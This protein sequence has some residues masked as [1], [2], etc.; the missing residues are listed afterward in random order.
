MTNY[1]DPPGFAAWEPQVLQ[2]IRTDPIWRTPAYRYAL[3]LSD[4]VELDVAPLFKSPETR[5]K[6]DQ[7]LRAAQSISANIADGYGRS[8]GAERAR[9]YEYAESSAREARDWYFKLRKYLT[10]EVVEQR[11]ELLLR[12]IKIL[13]AV[14]PRERVRRH[15][16]APCRRPGSDRR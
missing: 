7:L 9:F 16:L 5:E 4:L 10:P 2:S 11:D 3:W 15:R 14:I 6:A 13:T 1:T 8:S 12:I